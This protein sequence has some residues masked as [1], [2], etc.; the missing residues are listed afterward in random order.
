MLT[1]GAI[2]VTA[3]VAR[4]P[5]G[6]VLAEA[7]PF[8][9]GA[10]QRVGDCHLC[11]WIVPVPVQHD[12]VMNGVHGLEC[13]IWAHSNWSR[14]AEEWIKFSVMRAT[15][16]VTIAGRTLCGLSQGRTKEP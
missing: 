6:Q 10:A 7:L 5:I 1:R 8:A 12:V 3:G 4:M 16:A 14:E 11:S 2:P 13:W 15:A 9:A